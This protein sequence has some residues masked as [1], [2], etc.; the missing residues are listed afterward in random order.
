LDFKIGE[1]AIERVDDFLYLASKI[2]EN[3]GTFLDIQQRINKARGAFSWFKNYLESTVDHG[4][5]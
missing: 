1:E 3:G 2:D 5:S 4:G